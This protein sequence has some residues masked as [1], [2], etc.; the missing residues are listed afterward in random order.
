MSADVDT[1][2]LRAFATVAR[3]GSINRAAARLGRTQPA[4]SQQ[5]RRLEQ[6]LGQPLLQR[7]TRGIT[8]SPAGEALLPYAERML[9]LAE[10]LYEL[11]GAPQGEQHRRI[12]LLAEFTGPRLSRVL[13]D[14][15]SANP[16]LRLRVDEADSPTL[17]AALDKGELDLVVSSPSSRLADWTVDAQR[18][19]Q[20]AWHAADGFHL[21]DGPLPLLLFTPPCSWRERTLDT[22]SRAGLPWCVVFESA[23]FSA[24]QAAVEAGLGVAALLAA[25]PP[26]G[27]CRLDGQLPPLP[28]V[29]LAVYRRHGDDDPLNQRLSQ[30]FQREL[31]ALQQTL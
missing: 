10:Q 19:C 25:T 30:L 18:D 31:A 22:L 4:L 1:A 16:G 7:S 14:F 28:T 24:L 5:I 8:L 11:P 15:A 26:A 9:A 3:H 2:L 20:L 21:P 12:G 23:S 29:P 6:Q 13:A 27:S 17:A